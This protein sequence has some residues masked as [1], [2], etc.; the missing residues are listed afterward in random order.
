[1]V[2]QCWVYRCS[3]VAK[4]KIEWKF[5]L[6]GSKGF[7][8]SISLLSLTIC[9]LSFNCKLKCTEHFHVILM[10]FIILI[11]VRVL[12]VGEICKECQRCSKVTGRYVSDKNETPVY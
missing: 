11:I 6:S 4:F 5:Y 7:P 10:H 1:M 9:P 3:K 8:L 2:K 12:S